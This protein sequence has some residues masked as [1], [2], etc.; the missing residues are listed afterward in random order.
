M[1]KIQSIVITTSEPDAGSMFDAPSSESSG[2]LQ[3]R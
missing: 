2:V 3:G 1:A